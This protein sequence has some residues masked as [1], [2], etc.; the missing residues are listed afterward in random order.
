[1]GPFFARDILPEIGAPAEV[2][3]TGD[4]AALDAEES[5]FFA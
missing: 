1:M 4:S 2:L 5:I 3:K